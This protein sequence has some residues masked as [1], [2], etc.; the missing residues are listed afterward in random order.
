M[1]RKYDFCGCHK[2]LNKSEGVEIIMDEV[3]EMIEAWRERKL[4]G[5]G[6]LPVRDEASD[7]IWGVNRLIA[8]FFGKAYIRVLPW[9]K[10][11][12]EKVFGRMEDFGCVR[13]KRNL[14]DG[15]CAN[16]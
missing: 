8:A 1:K 3:R 14:V 9:E 7:V 12:Y 2:V 16:S 15:K 4:P 13:S 10:M 5:K 11:H 6:L